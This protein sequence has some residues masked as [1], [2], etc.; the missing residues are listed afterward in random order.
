MYIFAEPMSDSK[1]DEIQK[2]AGEK[3]DELELDLLGLR[4]DAPVE[5]PPDDNS[6]LPEH[7]AM[8]NDAG[9]ASLLDS[10]SQE[11]IAESV[12]SS[13]HSNAEILEAGLSQPSSDE[14]S[15][16][17]SQAKEGVEV[18]AE[19]TI[20]GDD[21]PEGVKEDI[22]AGVAEDS[23]EAADGEWLD[24]VDKEQEEVVPQGEGQDLLAMTLT[25]RNK[26]NGA[27][28]TR[29]ENLVRSDRWA[30]EYSLTEIT[31]ASRAWQLYRACQARRRKGLDNE[32][33][34]EADAAASYY[35]RRLREMSTRGRE[36]RKKQDERFSRESNVV[37][38]GSASSPEP[39]ERTGKHA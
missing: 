33:H 36:W 12:E 4:P 17:E 16:T 3:V 18:K 13:A 34:D 22:G 1:A 7:E 5:T 37:L 19:T 14:D 8:S 24:Q 29:P 25:L 26:V 2:S 31:S 9:W 10:T 23:G 35:I 20:S 11:P 15:A 21:P 39:S 27:H 30:V 6:T 32:G 38:N 28:V